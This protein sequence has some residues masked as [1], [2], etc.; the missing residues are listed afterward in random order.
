MAEVAVGAAV[1]VVAVAE[2][3]GV[4]CRTRCRSRL[5]LGGGSKLAPWVYLTGVCN[6]RHTS[7]DVLTSELFA[8]ISTDDMHSLS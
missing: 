7:A 5:Q 4:G 8:K 6:K 1:V 3:V 2:V